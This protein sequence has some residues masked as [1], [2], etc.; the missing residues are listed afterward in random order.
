[1]DFGLA[2]NILIG[3]VP[4]VIIGSNMSVK[5]PQ[6]VLRTAL[7]L[8]LIAAG[9]TIMN[10]A[11][12]DLVP[13]VLGVAALAFAALFAIQIRLR[14]EVE[15]DPDEQAELEHEI[16]LE[17]EGAA[18]GANGSLERNEETKAEPGERAEA[19]REPALR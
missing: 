13:Y 7:G 9:V 10:K 19:K 16:E 14:K 18:N 17:V 5:W 8:V 2:A 1:M 15:D 11:N 12:T 4:G 3:S 6:G